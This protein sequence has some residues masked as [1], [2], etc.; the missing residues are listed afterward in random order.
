MTDRTIVRLAHPAL[1]T[2]VQTLTSE[3][4]NGAVFQRLVDE[5][6]EARVIQHEFHH[7]NGLVYLNR[8]RDLE[9]LAFGRRWDECLGESAAGTRPPGG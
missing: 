1:R 3:N 6:V 4:L 9:S 8:M 2:P 7:P 5:M